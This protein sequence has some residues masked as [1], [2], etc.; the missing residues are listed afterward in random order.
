[1]TIQ[2]GFLWGVGFLGAVLALVAIVCIVYLAVSFSS[3]MKERRT[4]AKDA[5]VKPGN[6]LLP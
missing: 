1:M 2:D 5:E 4:S 6:Q 3:Y